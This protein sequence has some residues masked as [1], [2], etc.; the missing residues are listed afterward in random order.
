MGAWGVALLSDDIAE[1]IKL[2]YKDLLA[3]EYSNEDASRI[4][5]EEYKNELDDEE[6]IVFWLVFSSIQWKLGRLQENVKQEALQIIESGAD[7]ARWEEEPKLQKKREVVLNK[8]REQ[9][10]SR[11]PEAK[12]VPKRFIANT[13]LKAGDAVSYELVSGSCIILKVIEIIE[14]W[15]GDRYPLF[16]ICDWE[17][18]EVPSKEQIN[19]FGLKKRIYEDGK[20]EMMKLAIYPSGKRDN[21]T[22][23]MQIVAENVKVVLNVGTPYTVMSWKELDNYLHEI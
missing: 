13:S 18:K 8:L 9:L 19:Q 21:P 2:L 16:E 6:T 5:I 20:Q 11:Q 10:H 12:K 3:N 4:V 7:L 17:G 22:K 14:E 1:D 23:R 15:H